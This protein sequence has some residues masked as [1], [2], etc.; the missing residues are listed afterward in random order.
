MLKLVAF[1]LLLATTE[2]QA[3]TFNVVND[4]FAVY[5][6]GALDTAPLENTLANE[7]AG[8]QT[9]VDVEHEKKIS[10]ELGVFIAS[11]ELNIRMGLEFIRPPE[12][13]NVLG[14]RTT[15]GA[16]MYAVKSEVSVLAPKVSIESN[17][18]RWPEARVF[19][20]AGYGY[21]MLTAMNSYSIYDSPQYSGLTDFKEE[22]TATGTLLEG[23]IGYENL[24]ADTTTF[25]LEAGYRSLKFDSIDYKKATTN[26]QGNVNG[27][28]KA[29]N[30][31]G[32]PRTL[33]LSG[34]I[35]AISFR[36]WM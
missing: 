4:T 8:S 33:D 30:T 5:L 28:Q 2:A 32:H 25:V 14:T 12:A 13:E 9:Q 22:L 7:S 15:D 20:S 27:G 6:R 18:K 3:R 24:L 19:I 11:P 29:L 23:T 36:F 26:F 34:V 31:A 17:L 1:S 21:A 35:F 10:G 16:Q